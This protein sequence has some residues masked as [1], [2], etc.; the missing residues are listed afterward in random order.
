MQIYCITRSRRGRHSRN[1]HIGP[2]WI[3]LM[4]AVLVKY[5]PFV[6]STLLRFYLHS[7]FS[8]HSLKNTHNE[9]DNFQ[10][11]ISVVYTLLKFFFFACKSNFGVITWKKNFQEKFFAR[12]VFTFR[13]HYSLLQNFRSKNKFY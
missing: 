13:T 1:C 5:F 2:P 12:L 10:V 3:L 4:N 11:I 6:E 7:H 9:F 8:F